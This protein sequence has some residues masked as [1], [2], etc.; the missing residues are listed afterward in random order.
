MLDCDWLRKLT[1]VRGINSEVIEAMNNTEPNQSTR[2]IFSRNVPL[3]GAILRKMGIVTKAITQNGMFNQKMYL[4]D[5]FSASAPPTTGPATDPNAHIIEINPNHF[6]R[7]FRVTISVTMTYVRALMP[8]PP[9]PCTDRPMSIMVELVA[10][11][12]ITAPTVKKV[13]A[14]RSNG[15]LP[16][17]CERAGQC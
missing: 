11:A 8:P 17:A 15:F 14:M 9:T 16:N 6:P 1:Q 2:P 12:A 4:Q 7:S 10:I 3:T 5:A 13:R